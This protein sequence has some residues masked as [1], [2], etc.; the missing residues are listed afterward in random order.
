MTF[1]PLSSI[2]TTA[3]SIESLKREM[4]RLILL[5]CL[6]SCALLPAA[7][8]EDQ[9]RTGIRAIPLAFAHGGKFK[10]LYD[11]RLRPQSVLLNNRL[12]IVYHGDASPTENSRATAYPM[13]ITYG[14]Q[15]RRFSKPVRLGRKSSSDHHY[16]PI[17]WADEDEYF[18]LG[19]LRRLRRMGR[20]FCSL[21]DD[22]VS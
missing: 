20:I 5:L 15:D 21:C 14:P 6:M 17:I 2:P 12:Y 7:S 10:M 8:G 9:L 19:F 3:V 16:S 22:A 18:S 11:C 13:L 1:A 4:E